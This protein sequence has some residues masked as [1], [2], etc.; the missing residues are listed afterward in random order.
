VLTYDDKLNLL[1]RA[2]VLNEPWHLSYPQII[3]AEGETW[4][5]PEAQRSGA[6]TLYRAIDFPTRWEPAHRIAL[7]HV[8]IDATPLFHH[9]LWWLF[10]TSGSREP[11]K[12]SA[13]HIAYADRLHGPWTPHLMNPVRTDFASAR[14]GG[15]ARVIDGEVVLPVQDCA[16]TYGGALSLLH[17]PILT[18]D[19]VEMTLGTRLTAPPAFAPYVE[20]MHTLSAAG[21]VTLIDAKRTELSL[22]GLAIEARR[23]I[24]KL[25]R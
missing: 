13:L 24:R 19:R 25:R 22:R 14:P 4:L 21:P 5:L 16:T 1:S 20:G 15:T 18:P 7:D 6:L 3:E 17:F 12:M 11:D 2:P 8:P 9:G 10:Y 23:E